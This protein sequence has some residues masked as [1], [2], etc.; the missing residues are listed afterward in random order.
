MKKRILIAPLN[1][2]LGHAT[3]CIPIIHELIKHEYEPIIASDGSSL[4]LLKKEFPELIHL[5][6]PSYNIEYSEQGQSLK[7][8]LIKNIPSIFKTI[9]VEKEATEQIIK[10]YHISG[11]I[12]DNRL[13]VYNKQI[14]SV[15]ITHQLRVLSGNTT[16]FTSKIHQYIIK[17]FDVCWIPDAKDEPNFTGRLGHIKHAPIPLKYI[18]A[19]SR[20]KKNKLPLA[21]DLLVL[22]SG[23]EPQRALLEKKLLNELKAFNGKIVFVKGII[24]DQQTKIIKNQFTI[25]NFMQSNELEKSVNES[26]LVIAR[27]GY[28]SIMDLAKLGKRSFFIP[29]PGQFEQDYLAKRLKQ[30]RIAPYCIQDSFTISNLNEVEDFKG[31]GSSENITDFKT[32]FSLF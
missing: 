25:Y 13:G 23:P 1:W 4:L 17:R 31:L 14:P 8:K 9:K 24:E 10:K 21:N 6:L 26:K 30:L 28:T 12:S 5:E 2:G 16:W 18:G 27:S 20:F 15:Y 11:I 3:R 19:T 32:L 22:L 7:W 29:T